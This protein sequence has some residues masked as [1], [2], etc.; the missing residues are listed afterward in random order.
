MAFS[1]F[2][3]Q[4]QNERSASPD[5]ARPLPAIVLLEGAVERIV[6]SL[7]GSSQAGTAT[8]NRYLLPLLMSGCAERSLHSTTSG[9]LTMAAF[10]GRS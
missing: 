1:G 4:L 5:T 9:L 7:R 2:N 6:A 8:E 3:F 10:C